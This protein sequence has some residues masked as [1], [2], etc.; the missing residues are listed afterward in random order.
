MSA[1]AQY[2]TAGVGLTLGLSAIGHLATIARE[3]TRIR[4][5]LTRNTL[6]DVLDLDERYR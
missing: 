2:I 1:L 3:L 6:A 4:E 5:L